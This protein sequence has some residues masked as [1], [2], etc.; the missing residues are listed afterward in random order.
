MQLRAV[1][2][3]KQPSSGKRDAVSCPLPD[4]FPPK[5]KGLLISSAYN[6]SMHVVGRQHHRPVTLGMA[7]GNRFECC[8]EEEAGSS[9][10]ACKPGQPWMS[11]TDLAILP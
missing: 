3:H 10:Q 1:G 4:Q 5:R 8:S 2:N 6:S 11:S 7:T 9:F